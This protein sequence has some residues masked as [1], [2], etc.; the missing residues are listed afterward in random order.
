SRARQPRDLLVDVLREEEEAA[1]AGFGIGAPLG[2][3]AAVDGQRE[4]I[5]RSEQEVEVAGVEG[6]AQ[7]DLVGHVAPEV[8]A[9][10]VGALAL[11]VGEA[12]AEAAAGLEA[13]A[14]VDVGCLG[15]VEDRET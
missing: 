5:E 9:E 4:E 8:P 2:L 7:V 13:A 12:H 15:V 1:G 14:E 6:A 10:E 3:G 11:G